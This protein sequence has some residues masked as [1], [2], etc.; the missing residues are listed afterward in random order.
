MDVELSQKFTMVNLSMPDSAWDFIVEILLFA[1]DSSYETSRTRFL[2]SEIF[3]Y[4]ES[5]KFEVEG[6]DPFDLWDYESDCPRGGW[7][8]EDSE[9]D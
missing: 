2:A 6:A 5:S 7:P 4:I 1:Q 8:E 3:E 9:A